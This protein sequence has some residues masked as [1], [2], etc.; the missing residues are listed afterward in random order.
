MDPYNGEESKL[1]ENIKVIEAM[2]DGYHMQIRQISEINQR[3]FET[4]SKTFKS[5]NGDIEESYVMFRK[6][7][8]ESIHKTEEAI[9]DALKIYS[10]GINKSEKNRKE[11]LD[12]INNQ[13]GDL[14]KKNLKQWSDLTEAFEKKNKA[15]ENTKAKTKN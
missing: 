3:F 11:L 4:F 2:M 5:A 14:I 7:T 9:K 15:P 8:E 1:D 10:L 13:M 6:K 12:K